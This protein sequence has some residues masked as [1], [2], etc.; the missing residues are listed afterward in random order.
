MAMMLSNFPC[1][2]SRFSIVSYKRMLT[3]IVPDETTTQ[4]YLRTCAMSV[5]TPEAGKSF[6]FFL[7]D[8]QG[9]WKEKTC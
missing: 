2:Y 9:R 4:K 1:V 5:L 3:A 6:G 7:G 8:I